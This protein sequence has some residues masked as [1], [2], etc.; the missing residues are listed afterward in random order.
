MFS[1]I[2]RIS[3]YLGHDRQNGVANCDKYPTK[4]DRIDHKLYMQ[5]SSPLQVYL[6][7]CTQKVSIHSMDEVQLSQIKSES[8]RS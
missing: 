6:N 5:V 3:M 1:M 7:T 2:Y 4:V 8:L